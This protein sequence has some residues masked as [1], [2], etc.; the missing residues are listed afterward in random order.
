MFHITRIFV[1]PVISMSYGME[2]GKL[3]D[4]DFELNGTIF[5][6]WPCSSSAVCGHCDG[7][8]TTLTLDQG[9]DQLTCRDCV[10]AFPIQT[11]KLEN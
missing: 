8:Q 10:D 7:S 5:S 2:R 4:S 11:S 3:P 6:V 9:I 1:M